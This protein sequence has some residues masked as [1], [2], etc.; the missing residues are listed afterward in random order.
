MLYLIPMIWPKP[1][2]KKPP[3]LRGLKDDIS[4]F[5]AYGSAAEILITDNWKEIGSLIDNG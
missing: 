2:S 4:L 1:G 3:L 5:K